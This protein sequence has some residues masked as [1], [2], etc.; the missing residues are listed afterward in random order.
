MVTCVAAID[1]VI[2]VGVGQLAEVFVGLHEC[3]GVLCHIAEVN[4]VVGKAMYEGRVD[5]AKCL[6]N[7]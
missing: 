1:A 2:A 5:L 4:I 3:F 6:Q 7:V